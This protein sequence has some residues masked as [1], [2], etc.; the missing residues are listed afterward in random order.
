MKK[1][2]KLCRNETERD[3][4]SPNRAKNHRFEETFFR[5]QYIMKGRNTLIKYHKIP[6]SVQMSDGG[7]VY[8]QAIILSAYLNINSISIT[9]QSHV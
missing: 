4:C 2:G 1:R 5:Y 9:S 6:A 3:N 7:S 8:R